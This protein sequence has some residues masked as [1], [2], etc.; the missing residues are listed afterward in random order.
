MAPYLGGHGKALYWGALFEGLADRGIAVEVLTGP[1]FSR[2]ECPRIVQNDTVAFRRMGGITIPSPYVVVSLARIQC[3]V[4]LILEF[5][6][7][8]LVATVMSRLKG[9]KSI[10]LVENAPQF[11]SANRGGFF[12]WLRK[13]QV[14]LCTGI[15]T[16]NQAGHDYLVRELGVPTSKI[17]PAVY[18]T[19]SL[20]AGLVLPVTRPALQGRKVKFS[21]IGR[22]IPVKGFQQLVDEVALLKDE[23]RSR[24]EIDIFGAGPLK[25]EL[26]Q[27]IDGLQLSGVIRLQGNVPYTELGKRLAEADAYIMPSL[28]DYRSLASFEALSLGLPLLISRHD[29]AHVEVLDEG[30]NGLLIDPLSRGSLSGAIR[31]IL[32]DPAQLEAMAAHSLRR[33]QEFTVDKAVDHIEA[34][35]CKAMAGQQG[36][37]PGPRG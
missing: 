22:L 15:L 17:T 18:L 16:N 33:A 20:A 30:Q 28:G 10:L 19:S 11:T 9:Q 25:D 36:W 32:D 14:R 4:M 37:L 2:D 5:S 8:A 6:I 26:Q 23:E 35:A 13:V 24:L 3:D 34:A 31:R 7:L 21:C 1:R 29:G 12:K 27:Q